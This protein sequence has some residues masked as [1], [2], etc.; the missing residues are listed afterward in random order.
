MSR[1]RPLS[2]NA[3]CVLDFIRERREVRQREARDALRLST[4]ETEQI[5]KRL[6]AGGRIRQVRT[7]RVCGVKRP[8]G[9]WAPSEAVH[10]RCDEAFSMLSQAL[11]GR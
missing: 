7:E 8:V 2:P 9:V 3:S 11:Y 1:G 10:S 5:F 4:T 6:S